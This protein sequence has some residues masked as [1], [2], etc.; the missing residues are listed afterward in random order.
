MKIGFIV[1]PIAGMG[2][3]V[4]LKGTDGADILAEA[5]A[6]GAMPCAPERAARALK[7]LS[8]VKDSLV[9]F[10]GPGAMG[11]DLA[12]EAGFEPM[13]VG[14][15]SAQ[16][17][18]EDTRRVA[19]I[20]AEAGVELLLFAGGDGT[21]RDIYVAVG[22]E[23]TV[24]GIPAGVKIHSAVFGR[25]PD[26]AG[27]MAALWVQ[28]SIARTVLAEVMDINEDDY[29]REILSAKLYGYLRI[30]FERK[31]LQRLKCGSA[32]QEQHAQEAIA[33]DM[34]E[35]LEADRLYLIGAGST[36]R[37]LMWLLGL[38]SSL[39]GVDAVKNGQLI[40]KDLSEQQ[41]LELMGG[42][43]ASLIV[44]PIG[45]QGYLF[46]RGNLQL[47]PM[48]L[49]HIEKECIYVLATPAK[50]H[51][52]EGRPL[53]LDTGDVD[54]DKSLSGHYRIITGYHQYIIYK[55]AL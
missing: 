53:L 45:G 24:V 39:L 15:V 37:S 13:V 32:D 3:A 36:T 2:G 43:P 25:N 4:G 5:V 55:V 23:M 31:C 38:E 30:P 33:H 16:T 48:V 7:T 42:E 22:E 21:A 1:N 18:A 51:G 6:R 20:M 12:R 14:M 44:T 10:A 46:G 50:I 9:L 27:E 41:I 19:Q 34:A 28:G 54:L 40:G 52:L 29:R 8:A 49:T 35:Q 11:E 47:S 26:L 17:G